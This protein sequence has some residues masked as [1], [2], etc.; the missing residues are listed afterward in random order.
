MSILGTIAVDM[1]P[2][3]VLAIA[4]KLAAH[5]EVCTA[6][7]KVATTTM[8]GVMNALRLHNESEYRCICSAVLQG[9]FTDQ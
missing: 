7:S 5:E 4:Q 3:R 1:K 8:D 6:L 2:S 9:R